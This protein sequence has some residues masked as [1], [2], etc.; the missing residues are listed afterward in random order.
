VTATR[1]YTPARAN[2]QNFEHLRTF[3][4]QELDKIAQAFMVTAQSIDGPECDCPKLT[5]DG[6]SPSTAY[7]IGDVFWDGGAP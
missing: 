3:L 2:P 4:Q 7:T 1:R 6:G 5:I